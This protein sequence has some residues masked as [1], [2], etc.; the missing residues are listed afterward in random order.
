[1]ANDDDRVTREVNLLRARETELL[2][3]VA[4]ANARADDY[5]RQMVVA[6]AEA[7]RLRDEVLDDL[8][9]TV[10]QNCVYDEVDG[11]RRYNHLFMSIYEDACER[12]EDAGRLREVAPEIF[13]FVADEEERTSSTPG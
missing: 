4:D 11:I 1:M 5:H 9:A 6:Q 2:R 12:L 10:R 3:Q 8:T 7:E 13:V